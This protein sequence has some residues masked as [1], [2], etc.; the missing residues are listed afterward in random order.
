LSSGASRG[1][2]RCSRCGALL[3]LS[4]LGP[5]ALAAGDGLEVAAAKISI[6]LSVLDVSGLYGPPDGLRAL[7]YAFCIPD[8]EDTVARVRN[9]DKSVTIHRARGRIGSGASELLCIGNTHQPG[10]R[11]VLAAFS[12]LP[13]VERVGQAFFE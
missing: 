11:E 8:R 6:T 12:R 4:L 5:F 7:D 1:V 13:Y 9:I 3:I 10:Y 2:S